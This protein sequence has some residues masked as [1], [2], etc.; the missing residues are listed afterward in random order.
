METKVCTKCGKEYPATTEFFY[1]KSKDKDLL[2]WECKSCNKTTCKKYREENKDII[3]HKRK[4]YREENREKI[5]KHL[6]STKDKR[7]VN[8]ITKQYRVT[9]EF[10]QE[11]MNNQLGCCAI[12]NES[13]VSPS[14]AASYHIDHNHTTGEVRGLLCSKCNFLLGF[15]LDNKDILS[16]AVSY[17]IKYS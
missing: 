11:I 10:L 5:K 6:E 12:C 4:K 15:A 2:L 7:R 8:K 9:E 1:K 16:S 3:Y 14:S 13:L 17:L